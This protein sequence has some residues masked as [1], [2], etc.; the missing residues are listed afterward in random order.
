MLSISPATFWRRQDQFDL[1][2]IGGRVLVTSESI[3]RFIA[4]LEMVNG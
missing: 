2:R 3:D 4:D 1:R